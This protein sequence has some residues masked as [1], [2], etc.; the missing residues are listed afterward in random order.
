MS[1]LKALLR[2]PFFLYLLIGAGLAYRDYTTWRDEVRQPLLDSI[3]SKKG[4]VTR[5]RNEVKRAEEFDQRRKEKL[6]QLQDLA[7]N[8]ESTANAMPRSANVPDLLRS[9]AD[10]A[11]KAGIDFTS[12]RPG[13][14]RRKE[15]LVITPIEVALK[16]SYVQVMTFLDATAHLTRVVAS[17]KLSLDATNP[18][19]GGVS[20]LAAQLTLVTYH[21]EEDLKTNVD[22]SSAPTPAA[23][24]AT[25]AP[26]QGSGKTKGG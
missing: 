23:P 26:P 12:F 2:I 20:A 9:L 22:T 13:A 21:L 4:E 25:P 14:E 17:E 10:I 5:L 8:L 19:S 18:G 7:R 15:F 24:P 6:S 16:G 3:E 11:D 1:L